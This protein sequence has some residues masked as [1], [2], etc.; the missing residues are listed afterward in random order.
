MESKRLAGNI[1]F[2]QKAFLLVHKLV[3]LPLHEPDGVGEEDLLGEEPPETHKAE[4]VHL[5]ELI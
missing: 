1:P 3:G 2:H 4:E 5:G